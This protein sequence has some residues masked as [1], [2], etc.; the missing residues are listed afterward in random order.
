M[1]GV[2]VRSEA[3]VSKKNRRDG[4]EWRRLTEARES[5]IPWREWGPYSSED[6]ILEERLFG[7]TNNEGN[8]GEDV[9]E[10]DFS[11]DWTATHSYIASHQTGWTGIVARMMHLSATTTTQAVVEIGKAAAVVER[12]V[13]VAGR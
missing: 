1:T 4:V 7:L 5:Q 10:Y 2:S 9:K 8:H 3:S 6:V 12:E 13:A 11:L